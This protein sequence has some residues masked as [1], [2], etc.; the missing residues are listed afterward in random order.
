MSEL[1]EKIAQLEHAC[2]QLLEAHPGGVTEHE[3]LQLLRRAPHRLM[4]SLALDDSL[5]LFQSHFLLFHALYRLRDRLRGERS[6]ELSISALRIVLLPYVAGSEAVQRSD[7]LRAYYLD[8]THLAE[9]GRQE[10]EE[11]LAG[12]WQKAAVNSG[13]KD[14][15]LAVLEL[16]EP[17]SLAEIKT[18]YRRLAMAHHPDRG[19]E[20]EQMHD[21]NCALETLQR[22][23]S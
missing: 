18:Q 5:G 23:Y 14:K 16:E 3:L 20:T 19:G 12:F 2:Q 11:M 7:P 4:P 15:A 9:T 6:A 1:E 10:V 8:L 22:Y 13:D 17:V 21:L